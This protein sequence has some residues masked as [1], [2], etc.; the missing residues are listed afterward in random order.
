[1]RIVVCALLFLLAALPLASQTMV[2]YGT[3]ASGATAGSAGVRGVGNSVA[4]ALGKASGAIQKAGESEDAG[5][6]ILTMT[7]APQPVQ[8]PGVKPG[9]TSRELLARM[10]PPASKTET[11]TYG[12]GASAVN[13]TLR[14]G[15]VVAVTPVTPPAPVKPVSS[16][17]IVILQ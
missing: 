2:E 6:Q 8:L 11:W 3:A 14:A 4:S 13:V 7:P 5:A 16:E 17:D 9:I 1:M 12:K 15:K 10:G